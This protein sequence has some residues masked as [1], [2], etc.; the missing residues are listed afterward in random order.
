M[1]LQVLERQ[2]RR[3]AR[4]A[5]YGSLLLVGGMTWGAVSFLGR[6]SKA[7]D[8]EQQWA[9]RD[10]PSLPEVKL[11]QEY[12]RIDTSETTGDELAGARFLARQFEAAGIPTRIEQL[13]PRKANLYAWLDGKDPRPLVLHNHI[14]VSPADPKEWF[15]PPFEARIELPWIYGRGVFDMKSIAIA[16]MAAMIDLKKSGVPLNRSVLFLATSSEERGSRLGVRHLIH[17]HPETVRGFWAV[18]TEGGVVEA[19][20]RQDIKF[21]GTEFAQKRYADLIVCSDR[22]EQLE[23]LRKTLLE[24]GPTETDLRLT[25]ETAAVL[26]AYAPTRDRGDFRDLLSHPEKVLGDIAAFRKLPPYLRSMFRNEAVPFKVEEARGGG[27]QMVIKFQLLPGED[28]QAVR[29]K[30]VPR[31]LT[32]GMTTLLDEPPSAR[33]GSPLDHPVFE[34]IE[35]TVRDEYPGTPVGPYFLAWTATDARFFRTL[36]VPVYGFSPFLVMNTDT[37]SVDQ[38]NERFALPGFVEGVAL[39]G[40]L[41]R[42]LVSD[43]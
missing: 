25:P 30:L 32:F 13:G 4:I 42:R 39:Y 24:L 22:R 27:Y 36:G 9:S 28:L 33:G 15:S 14:D 38:P 16:Q 3:A 2:R 1:T 23:E 8:S 7:Q 19:R 20:S 35:A 41:V 40:K 29:E 6:P 26:A 18:L 17:L 37:L 12:V 43:T 5:L 31:W 11:L 21:W 34:A 10:Y